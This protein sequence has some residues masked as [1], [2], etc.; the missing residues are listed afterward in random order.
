MDSAKRPLLLTSALALSTIGSSVST[1]AY[2]GTFLFYEKALPQIEK[3]TNDL[4]AGMI[5]RYYILA[6]GIISFVS[7]IGV[8]KMWKNERSGF[9]F[10]LFAQA[11]LF[12]LP[13]INI[14][15][16]A[17]SSTNAIFTVLFLSIYAVF[18]K[19]MQ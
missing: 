1:V 13:L 19:S 11:C 2:L 7:L 10:Y 4:T 5:S 8:L 17:F 3:F 16:H 14:G 6:M 18:L 15:K 12:V 9:F